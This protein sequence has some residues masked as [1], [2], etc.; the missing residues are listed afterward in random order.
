MGW[1]ARVAQDA[2]YG[3][4]E[5]DLGTVKVPEQPT[6]VL[7]N[8][9][10]PIARRWNKPIARWTYEDQVLAM[11]E[12]VPATKPVPHELLV[13]TAGGLMTTASDYVRFML[14]M[15]DGGPRR[16]WQVSEQSRREMLSR[17]L[18]VGGGDFYRGLGWQREDHAG[19]RSL[20]A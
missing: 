11:R 8:A 17:Q 19:M 2:A 10:L 1:D 20:R 14:L 4:D 13:N 9:L 5:P 16:F 15:M 7:G 3:H 6:R 12:A 18:D